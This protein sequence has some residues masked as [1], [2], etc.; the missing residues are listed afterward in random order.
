MLSPLSRKRKKLF[1]GLKEVK[2]PLLTDDSIIHVKKKNPIES[3]KK[4]TN[5]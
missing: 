2:F 4:G 1:S 5:K 3:R